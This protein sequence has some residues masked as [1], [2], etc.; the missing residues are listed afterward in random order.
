VE[1]FVNRD[2]PQFPAPQVPGE[3]NAAL[4]QER[5]GFHLDA[6]DSEPVREGEGDGRPGQ[7][8]QPATR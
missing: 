1:E 3:H 4:T 6:P 5:G 2:A 7:R 8:R